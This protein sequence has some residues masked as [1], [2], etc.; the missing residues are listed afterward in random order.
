M[1][2][3]NYKHEALPAGKYIRVLR[4][5]PSVAFASEIKCRLEPLSLDSDILQYE[6]LSYVW[7]SPVGD[8]RILCSGKE[9]FVTTN[10][11]SALRYLRRK[12]KP[13][14]LWIDAI[15]IDQTSLSERSHQV[16]LMGEVYSMAHKTLIWLDP[17]T[18]DSLMDTISK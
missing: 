12:H 17:G 3:K 16:E 18:N 8:K 7:G 2:E 15:C 4:L 13:R 10:C 1:E 5:A 11:L 14:I 9:L 6:A